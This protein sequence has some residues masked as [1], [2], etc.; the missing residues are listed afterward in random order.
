MQRRRGQRKE[1]ARSREDEARHA[2]SENRLT[3]LYPGNISHKP[4]RSPHAASA[5]NTHLP[6]VMDITDRFHH[7]SDTAQHTN[8]GMT[9]CW[10]RPG[11]LT[12]LKQT[13]ER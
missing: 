7:I 10:P 8:S 2:T 11:E 3:Y 5:S 1:Q 12:S 4:A 13:L 6:L 9:Y